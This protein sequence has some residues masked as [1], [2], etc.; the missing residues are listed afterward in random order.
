MLRLV[1]AAGLI[2][3]PALATAQDGAPPQ[4]IRSIEIRKGEACPKAQSADE[5]VVC[6]TVEEPYRIPSEFRDEGAAQLPTNQSWVNRAATI[7]DVSAVAGGLPDT[8]SPVGT[9]GQTGCFK[10]AP[11]AQARVKRARA[12]SDGSGSQP[13]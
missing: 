2:A 1:V 9:G 12:R 11:R 4:R 5:V 8:C 6:R 13:Q 10:Q 3:T 7:D